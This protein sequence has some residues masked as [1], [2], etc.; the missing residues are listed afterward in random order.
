[1]QRARPIGAGQ[2]LPSLQITSRPYH[3]G[4]AKDIR[5]E[6]ATQTNREK[7]GRGSSQKCGGDGG[8]GGKQEEDMMSQRNFQRER[9]APRL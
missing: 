3:D 5:A 6:R 1:M 8:Q 9:E 7:E 4:G 2:R